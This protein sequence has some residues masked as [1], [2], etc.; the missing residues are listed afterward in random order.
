MTLAEESRETTD[1]LWGKRVVAAVHTQTNML[2]ISFD[3]TTTLY[4]DGDG[5]LELSIVG[6]S[7]RKVLKFLNEKLRG[8]CGDFCP[9]GWR[10]GI[11]GAM[12]TLEFVRGLMVRS[13]N[14]R[15]SIRSTSGRRPLPTRCLIVHHSSW[16]GFPP[17][18]FPGVDLG[19]A[20][21]DQ[22]HFSLANLRNAQLRNSSLRGARFSGADLRAANLPE[23]GVDRRGDG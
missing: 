14:K 2:M 15:I 17:P 3:D 21:A 6:G 11:H 13:S 16:R 19:G 7:R 20:N 10:L 1:L 23:S 4:V 9:A 18:T 22:A 8:T 5:D 12:K